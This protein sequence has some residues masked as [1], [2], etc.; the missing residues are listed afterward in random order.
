VAHTWHTKAL[1]NLHARELAVIKAQSELEKVEADVQARLAKVQSELQKPKAKAQAQLDSAMAEVERARAEVK[2]HE[3]SRDA[4]R[5]HAMTTTDWVKDKRKEVE[6][7]RGWMGV[8][9]VSLC[10]R[11]LVIHFAHTHLLL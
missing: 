3:V 1:Q 6:V 10:Q 9:E 2:A 4:S 11:I 5:K 7:L 8:D